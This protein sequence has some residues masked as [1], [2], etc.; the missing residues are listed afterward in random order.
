MFECE[1]LPY[2]VGLSL[3]P[4]VFEGRDVLVFID[5]E[6]AR[7]TFVKAFTRSDEALSSWTVSFPWKR[8]WMFVHTFAESRRHPTQQM[9]PASFSA[10]NSADRTRVAPRCPSVVSRSQAL[11]NPTSRRRETSWRGGDPW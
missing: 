7:K 3:L 5:N 11:V 4:Q 6:A 1:L 10:R 2:L 8:T 9:A